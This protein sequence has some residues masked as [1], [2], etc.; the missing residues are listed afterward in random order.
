MNRVA[1]LAP[2]V[3]DLTGRLW[4]AVHWHVKAP[5]HA[6]HCVRLT[7]AFIDTARLASDIGGMFILTAF[8][9]KLPREG[10]EVA[11]S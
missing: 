7:P 2:G 1:G 6:A 11:G 10:S 8:H 9:L 4:P 3:Y 5:V